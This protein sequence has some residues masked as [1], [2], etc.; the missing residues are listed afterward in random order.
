MI[1]I[2]FCMCLLMLP[3]MGCGPK[4]TVLPTTPFTPEQIEKIQA[5]DRQVE[6]EESQGSANKPKKKK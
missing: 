3:A 2:L 6:N 4:E 5:E 1:R